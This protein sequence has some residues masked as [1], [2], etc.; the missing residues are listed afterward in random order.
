MPQ[1]EVWNGRDMLESLPSQAFNDRCA[2]VTLIHDVL[3]VIIPKGTGT[4]DHP[5]Q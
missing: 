4:P 1:A 5:W 2:Y 3:R